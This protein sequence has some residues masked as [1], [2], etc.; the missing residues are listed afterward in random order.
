MLPGGGFGVVL[1]LGEHGVEALVALLGLLAVPLDPLGH[2]VED[3]RLPRSGVVAVRQAPVLAANLRA[4]LAGTEPRAF[5]ARRSYLSIL[6]TADGRALLRY[7]GI[8]V[9][10][11]AARLI[12]DRLDRDYVRRFTA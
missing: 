11:R 7:G 3:L 5:R 1:H 12:K 4:A 9:H 6:N 10:S 2:Q 8:V